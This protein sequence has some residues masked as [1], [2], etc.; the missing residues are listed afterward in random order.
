MVVFLLQGY[1]WPF[2]KPVDADLLGLHDYHTII[3]KPM[4]LGTV[5]KKLE[6]R[7]YI[8]GN[9]FAEEVRLIFTNCYRYNST[10]SDVVMMARKLQV[11][12]NIYTLIWFI[13][14]FFSFAF[15]FIYLFVSPLNVTIAY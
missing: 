4:D 1:A 5:K 2:Y 8:N 10:E 14:Q 11:G 9:E 3:K 7:E 6:T 13:R 15:L 12:V